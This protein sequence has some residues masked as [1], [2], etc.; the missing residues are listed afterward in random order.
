[1]VLVSHPKHSPAAHERKRHGAH[2][3]QSKHY[4]KTY[5]PYL[6][7]LAVVCA[8]FA[9]NMLW[10]PT[11]QVLGYASDMSGD[12]LLQRTNIARLSQQEEPLTYNQ[13]LS[14]AA[15]AK[16][17]DMAKRDY[18]SHNT[19][20]GT[21][22]QVFADKAGYRYAAIGENLAYGFDGSAATINA[23]LSSSEHR[24]NVLGEEFQE[25]GFGIANAEHFQGKEQ[26]TIVVALYGK[27]SLAGVGSTQA[28][29][30]T[31]TQ[32]IR[33]ISR[34]ETISTTHATILAVTSASIAAI[35][36]LYVALKH[37]RMLKKVLIHGEL[38]IVR[39]H[40]LDLVLLGLGGIGFVIT[41]SAGV[42]H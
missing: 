11:R 20:E 10:T 38:F 6:T 28:T 1:M 36:T 17:N 8:G 13:S 14:E 34:V 5:W 24:A 35:A 9:F 19:P 37:G 12:S 3:R 15:Q 4:T 29:T 21:L 27:P 23:W 22:P 25:V 39:H 30:N 32:P 26:E 40:L 41:R 7:M 2:H 31:A 42:I 33:E 16:A 18:W